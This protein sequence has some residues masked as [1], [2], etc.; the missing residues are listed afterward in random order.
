MKID[1][2]LAN[3]FAN[4]K[5]DNDIYYV[6]VG[7]VD[8]KFSDYTQDQLF[9][10]EDNSWWFKY[11]AEVIHNIFKKFMDKDK[12]TIDIG[13]GNGFTTRFMEEQ[14]AKTVLLEPSLGACKNANKRGLNNVVCG[15]LSENDVFDN[16]IPQAMLLDVLEHIEDD[17]TFLCL[18][19]KKLQSGGG[20]LV[21]VPAFSCLWSS[22]DD[23]AG[24]YRRYNYK[25]L[26]NIAEKCGFEVKYENYFF[27]F[28]FL[29][30]LLIRVFLEKIGILK[31][32][33]SRSEKELREIAEKQF[34]ERKG[35]V[36]TILSF[37]EKIEIK[38]L[39]NG[40]KIKFGSS[41]ICVLEKKSAAL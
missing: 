14:N 11:R 9:T 7:D 8:S 17:E 10:L 16:S 41:L 4:L 20:I 12:I 21:T 31:K 24:H 25:Q 23:S 19:N 27:S 3:I 40:S 13:G 39:I 22:E 36:G 15:T 35:I 30:I 6:Y 37:L 34:K 38:R 18:L 33:S 1:K 29:P 26:R 5:Y 32:S 2:E 28:A